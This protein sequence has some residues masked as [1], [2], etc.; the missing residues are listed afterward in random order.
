MKLFVY[1]TLRRGESNHDLIAGRYRSVTPSVLR[2][3]R[4][5]RR[6]GLLFALPA[7]AEAVIAGE[8][9]EFADTQILRDL[10]RLEGFQGPGH[11]GNLYERIEVD[12]VSL[13][14]DPHAAR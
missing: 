4:V 13:Y 3:F 12:G 8:L 6:H 9:Y 1:G 5:E 7:A 2:G 11:P 14:V 10:D